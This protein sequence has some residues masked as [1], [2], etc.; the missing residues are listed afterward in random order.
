M[1]VGAEK[2]V[3]INMSGSSLIQNLGLGPAVRQDVDPLASD[4]LER[5]SASTK[6]IRST[7]M[8]EW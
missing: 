6:L 8:S 7:A 5:S 4:L 1:A 2:A 3:K